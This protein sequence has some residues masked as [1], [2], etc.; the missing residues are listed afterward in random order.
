MKNLHLRRN[1]QESSFASLTLGVCKKSL[2]GRKAY[3]N[4]HV[5]VFFFFLPILFHWV[6]PP[7]YWAVHSWNIIQFHLHCFFFSFLHIN[8]QKIHQLKRDNEPFTEPSQWLDD[9]YPGL[10]YTR[11]LELAA[12]VVQNQLIIEGTREKCVVNITVFKMP[13]QPALSS[14]HHLLCGLKHRGYDKLTQ[15]EQRINRRKTQT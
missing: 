9:D 12:M 5:I 3:H 15:D 7:C 2:V 1:N 13:R 4:V 8:C 6:F 14:H 11:W 10:P